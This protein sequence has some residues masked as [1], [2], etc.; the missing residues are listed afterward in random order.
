MDGTGDTAMQIPQ[1]TVEMHQ[2]A[3]AI[4]IA[5]GLLILVGVLAAWWRL[6]Q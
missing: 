6:K 5:F 3:I 2:A 4:S 1:Y